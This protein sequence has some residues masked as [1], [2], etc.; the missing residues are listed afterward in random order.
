MKEQFSKILSELKRQLAGEPSWSKTLAASHRRTFHLAIFREPYL[1]FILDG[2]KTIETRFAKRA[3]PPYGKVADGDIL[4]LKRTGGPIVGVCTV[5]KV[6]LYKVDSENL[7][8]IKKKFGPAICA[9]GDSFWHER[10]DAACA[11]LM[12]VGRVVKIPGVPVVKRDRRG[13]VV[14]GSGQPQSAAL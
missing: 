9:T 8:D 1:R 2:R 10:K 11:T 4:L 5:E 6:W 13:W 12:L 14:F 7:I 3:C